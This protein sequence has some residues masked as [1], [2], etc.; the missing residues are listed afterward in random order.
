MKSTFLPIPF[1][2]LRLMAFV[3]TIS[4][5]NVSMK[6]AVSEKVVKEALGSAEVYKDS[7]PL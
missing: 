5:F 7:R 4:A 6:G 3:D 1:T 2:G